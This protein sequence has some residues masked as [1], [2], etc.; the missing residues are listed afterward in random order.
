[1][2]L[3]VP[4]IDLRT[5]AIAAASPGVNATTSAAVRLLVVA[6]RMPPLRRCRNTNQPAPSIN[7]S[8]S[9]RFHDHVSDAN[10]PKS[11]PIGHENGPP[12]KSPGAVSAGR[13]VGMSRWALQSSVVNRPVSA[14]P[15]SFPTQVVAGAA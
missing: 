2:A 15:L 11:V 9:R 13:P 8:P 3:S 5:L 1:M 14:L 7:G 10:V 4:V 6:R 12:G